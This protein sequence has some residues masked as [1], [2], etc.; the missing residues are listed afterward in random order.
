MS[1]IDQKKKPRSIW[2]EKLRLVR[3]RWWTKSYSQ[4]GED[5]VLLAIF[6]GYKTGRYVD[7]GS[8]HPRRY[9]N[10]RVLFE[11]GWQG[12][13]IDISK[14]KLALFDFDRPQDQNVYCAVSDK[15]GELKA[16]VFGT[17]SALDTTDKDMA[18]NWA[19]KFG[20]SYEE[21]QVP[22]RTLTSILNDCKL[23]QFDYLNIDVEGA[24]I[25]VLNGLDFSKYKPRCIS[26]EIHGSIEDV[27]TTET[28]K[29][30]KNQG[31][32]LH[33]WLRPTFIFV[34]PEQ[35]RN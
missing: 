4:H 13:N 33:A 27:P 34:L 2:K 30:L 20:M 5:L 6:D 31:Y 11:A 1:S 19:K 16:Y 23:E 25:S 29:I 24:E 14:R 35:A 15:P 26:I 10:T 7:V 3:K 12:I 28:Y 32:E 8:F 21:V 17:G 22:S 18:D 9:S